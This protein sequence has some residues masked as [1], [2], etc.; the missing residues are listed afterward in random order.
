[1][2][3]PDLDPDASLSLFSTGDYALDIDS[4]LAATAN[5]GETPP[6]VP[7]Y[8]IMALPTPPA[9]SGQLASADVLPASRSPVC[10]P[11]PG[12]SPPNL[13]SVGGP[14]EA[15]KRARTTDAAFVAGGRQGKTAKLAGNPERKNSCVN[16]GTTTTPMWRRTPDRQQ[17]LCNACGLYFKQYQRHRP[18]KVPRAGVPGDCLVFHQF[19]PEGVQNYAAVPHGGRQSPTGRKPGA[20]IALTRT[21]SGGAGFCRPLS[22]LAQAPFSLSSPVHG[23]NAVDAAAAW[24]TSATSAAGEAL[25]PGSE[26]RAQFAAGRQEGTFSFAACSSALPAAPSVIGIANR[27][28][29]SGVRSSWSPPSPPS[30]RVSSLPGSP[31]SPAS[32]LFHWTPSLPAAASPALDKAMRAVS[33]ADAV[34][35]LGIFEER[36]RHLRHIIAEIDNAKT[37]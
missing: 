7:P 19:K 2:L 20:S 11:S 32:A 4:G 15:S 10:A 36:C 3:V 25:P 14:Y 35:L 1:M 24:V 21:L 34:W 5:F 8:L 37:A 18:T 28:R 23:S 31:P 6:S 22:P 33:R 12:Q 29:A 30:S 26:D 13:A 9:V 17:T 16:C 27:E